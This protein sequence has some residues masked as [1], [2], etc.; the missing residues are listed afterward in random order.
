[1]VL[2]GVEHWQRRYPAWPLLQSLAAGKAMAGR[3]F[4]VETVEEAL[5]VVSG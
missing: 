4:L 2:V 3:I 5:E 1:M